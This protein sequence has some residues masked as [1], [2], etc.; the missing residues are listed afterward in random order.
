MASGPLYTVRGTGLAVI[1]ANF[2]LAAHSRVSL[3]RLR[4]VPRQR[5]RRH[6]LGRRLPVLGGQLG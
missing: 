6:E 5:R 3:E 2:A 4:V 1:T